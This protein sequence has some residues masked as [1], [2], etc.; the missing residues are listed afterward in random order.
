MNVFVDTSGLLAVLDASDAAHRR[1]AAAWTRLLEAG[2]A[3]VTTSYVLV[4]LT[5]LAQARLGVAAV[6]DIDRVLVPLMRVVWIDETFHTR[7]MAAL[8]AAGR[9]KLSLVDCVSF[10]V[11]REGGIAKAFTVDPDFRTQGFETVP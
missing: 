4:E 2:S 9:R 10:E 6:R 11:M 1:A 3:L 7:A 8:L 5:A